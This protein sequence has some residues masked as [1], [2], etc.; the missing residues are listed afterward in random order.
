MCM[1]QRW[2]HGKNIRGACLVLG[3]C[4]FIEH[5]SAWVCH[6]QYLFIFRIKTLCYL[7]LF[8]VSTF[9][10]CWN[11]VSFLCNLILPPALLLF[12]GTTLLR[13]RTRC[14]RKTCTLS[15]KEFLLPLVS[16][17][18]A[19]D[20][21]VKLMFSSVIVVVNAGF[22]AVAMMEW[23]IRVGDAQAPRL[24]ND[25]F[26]WGQVIKCIWLTKS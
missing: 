1:Q 19:N 25:A 4:P 16:M 14:D 8:Q 17:Q 6:F 13:V 20:N 24:G 26:F 12:A 21:M 7:L 2:W 23:V 9:H 15:E 11:F 18:M 3:Y 5:S 22:V 10:S